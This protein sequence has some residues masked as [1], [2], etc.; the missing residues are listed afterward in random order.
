M[1]MLKKVLSHP[2]KVP[3]AILRR[4]DRAYWKFADPTDART[5]VL[6]HREEQPFLNAPVDLHDPVLAERM[7]TCNTWTQEEYVHRI[8]GDL[9]L[10]PYSG[11][12]VLPGR[13]V[14]QPSL[15][16]HHQAKRPSAWKSIAARNSGSNVLE[17]DRIISFRDVHETNYFHCINDV[18]TKIPLLRTIGSIDVP[19][20]VG[21]ALYHKPFFQAML[22]SLKAA[23]VNIIDH[24]QRFIRAQEVIYCKAMPCSAERIAAVV[25]LL[26]KPAQQ[27]TLVEH[28]NVFLT[29]RPGTANGRV[30]SNGAAMESM[31]TE[32]GFE[33]IDT[34]SMPWSEQAELFRDVRHLVALHGA[35]LTNMVFRTGQ[36]MNVLEIFPGDSLP[37]H[38]YW[39]AMAS[40]FKYQGH[41]GEH[42]QANGTF[43]LDLSTLRDAVERL[44]RD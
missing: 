11:F 14:V 21:T 19:V 22:P 42:S 30:P 44:L 4:L 7:R 33:V 9:L 41:I 37:P 3:G 27:T 40:G 15:P 39:L 10:D 24:G 8:T 17:L 31:M 29:R 26:R 1:G 32:L 34:A 28:R 18:L 38:Y 16:Y 43:G 35:G 6:W 13:R 20:V 5:E 25:E 36:P 12:V 23:G 2:G